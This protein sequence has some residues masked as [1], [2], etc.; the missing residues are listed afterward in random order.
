MLRATFAVRADLRT[1]PGLLRAA[2]V[3]GGPTEFFTVTVW[4]TRDAMHAFMSSGAHEE[5]MWRWPEWLSSFWLGRLEPSGRESG[6]WRGL[7]LGPLIGKGGPAHATFTAP[8]FASHEQRPRDLE[9]Y[10]LGAAIAV[11][12][13]AVTV[14]WPG[15]FAAL[16]RH[17]EA[18][19]GSPGLLVSARGFSLDGEL[20][21]LSLWRDEQAATR[22]A[23]EAGRLGGAGTRAWSMVWRPLDEFGMWDGL[24]LRRLVADAAAGGPAFSVGGS[25]PC[26]IPPRDG[27]AGGVDRLPPR[28]HLPLG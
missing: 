16:R 17:T 27:G 7:A 15:A 28:V 14:G 21:A 22:A 26:L 12:R 23:E 10:R 5:I 24:R 2:N 6:K 3:I 1:T 9:R 20:V 8:A 25:R 13:P 19:E 18:V 11:L 4:T